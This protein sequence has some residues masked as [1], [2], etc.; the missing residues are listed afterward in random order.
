MRQVQDPELDVLEIDPERRR[1]GRLARG[2]IRR[3]AAVRAAA[4]PAAAPAVARSDGFLSSGPC[5]VLRGVGLRLLL[6]VALLGERRRQILAQHGQVDVAGLAHVA[7]GLREPV[8]ERTGVGR[9]EEVEVL[10]AAIEDRLGD[11]G[12]AVGDRE[13]LVLLDRVERDAQHQRLRADAC[14]PATSSRAT[15]RGGP[16]LPGV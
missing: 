13:R 3:P 8:E 14:R 9:A 16:G 12:Q 15:M 5:L 4:I 11:F 7:A 2:A 6:L 10:A 1:I